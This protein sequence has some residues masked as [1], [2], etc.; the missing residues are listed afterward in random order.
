MSKQ[1]NYAINPDKRFLYS[2]TVDISNACNID[3]GGTLRLCG[4][5]FDTDNTMSL[6]R[7]AEFDRGSTGF[8]CVGISARI[9]TRSR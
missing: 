4:Q 5:M 7:A 6:C 1:N 2:Y 8:S 9:V 3:V